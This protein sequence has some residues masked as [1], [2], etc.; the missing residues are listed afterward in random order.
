M[1][2]LFT[3]DPGIGSILKRTYP[4]NTMKKKILLFCCLSLL[5]VLKSRGQAD[6]L[7][8]SRYRLYNSFKVSGSFFIHGG[9]FL[10]IGYGFAA[11]G[12]FIQPAL[13]LSVSARF[14]K[15]NLGNRDRFKTAWQINTI[16]SPLVTVGSSNKTGFFEEINP[17]Y[18]GNVSSVY[19]NYMH[20]VTLGSS[21]VVMP[22]GLGLNIET[23][24]N[25]S[26]QL[27]Y[28]QLKVGWE[29][30][31]KDSLKKDYGSFQFNMYED[32]LFTDRPA[33]QALADNFD[34]FFTGGGNVQLRINRNFQIKLYNEVY[35]GNNYRDDFDYP[36]WVDSSDVSLK[37]NKWGNRFKKRQAR[38]AYQ[39]AGQQQFN[40]GRS[41]FVFEYSPQQTHRQRFSYQAYMGWQKAASMRS[42]NF[43]HSHINRIDKALPG[44]YGEKKLITRGRDKDQ[45][46]FFYPSNK[47]DKRCI[48][49]G[50][51]QFQT[52]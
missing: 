25:R 30:K 28:V 33:L 22:K 39:D 27:V 1:I 2:R 3:I 47:E 32:Y 11:R 21:F 46:H 40:K 14:G 19:S 43:I 31:N 4:L 26:Q 29:Y 7:V 15:N 49:G 6:E 10:G 36:D 16:I 12:K 18:F 41:F 17:A 20:A 8:S 23:S 50:G 42:Q 37:D 24:R 13:N 35:T 5:A 44:S 45:L 38:Y 9:G 34:R 52:Y 48:Y 51:I